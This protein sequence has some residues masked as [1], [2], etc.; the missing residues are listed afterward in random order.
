MSDASDARDASDASAASAA[1]I[2]PSVVD[3]HVHFWDPEVLRYPWL[4]TIPALRRAFGPAEY[5][6]AI[7]DA[8]VDAVVLVEAN[9]APAQGI[10]EARWLSGLGRTAAASASPVR[11]AGV[12]A[13]AELDDRQGLLEASL[14]AL[15]ATPRVRGVRHNIQGEAPGFCLRP[16][17]V[18]GVQQA[19]ARGLTF[20]LC[21]THDQLGEVAE[22]VARCPDTRFV[23]DHCGKPAIRDRLLEPWASDLARIAEHERVSCKLSGLLTEAGADRREEDLL[24]Y[25][26]RVA[27]CFGRERL[28]YGSDWPVLTLAG[29]YE[30]WLGFAT[31][32][33]ASWSEA[34]RS[35]FFAGTATRVYGL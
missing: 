29:G 20:D 19:G 4:E 31:R 25:A 23:L 21:A 27:E 8:R 9:P 15:S 3:A 11:I 10:R 2:A 30:D 1:R 26:E 32:F 5:A 7:A 33:T 22:L 18:R 28:M 12:V 14:D 17:F 6:S 24:P 35:A 34:E 13:Y 16:A